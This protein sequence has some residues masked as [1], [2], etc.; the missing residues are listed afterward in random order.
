[1]NEAKQGNEDAENKESTAHLSSVNPLTALKSS[2]KLKYVKADKSEKL[3]QVAPKFMFNIADG[4]FT[5]LHTL[6]ANEERA[7][8]AGGD[9]ASLS[10]TWHRRH[11][12]WLLSG[13]CVHGY[14]RWQDI[15]QDA[16]FAIIAEPFRHQQAQAGISNTNSYIEMKNK[17]LARRFK[18]LEQALVVEE[19]MR[20]AAHLNASGGPTQQM[21]QMQHVVVDPMSGQASSALSLNAKFSELE[22]LTDSHYH[23]TNNTNNPQSTSKFLIINNRYLINK[24]ITIDYFGE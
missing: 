17:F 16:R 21:L 7:A 10:V 1:M 14:G 2:H 9:E 19:Q 22:T 18:L 13:V 24:S 23:L 15:Q 12:Y 11:D 4:G 6:W 20:R 8:K 3:T 5:E